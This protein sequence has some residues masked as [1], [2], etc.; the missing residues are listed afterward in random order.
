MKNLAV[1]ILDFLKPS[2]IKGFF[3]VEWILLILFIAL[4]G[5]LSSGTLLVFLLP[6]VF[7]YLLASLLTSL[8]QREQQLSGNSGLLLIA[9]SLAFTDQMLK[10][11]VNLTLPYQTSLPIL[12]DWLHIANE[13]NLRGSWLLETLDIS[14]VSTMGLVLFVLPF[15]LGALVGHSY[16][17]THYRKSVWA[18]AAYLGLFSGLLSALCDLLLRG[19]TLDYIQIPNIVTADMKDVLLTAG[20]AAF[21]AEAYDNPAV[22]LRWRGWHQES[23]AHRQLIADLLQFAWQEC[24]R[25]WR[26]VRR[27]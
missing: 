1:Q 19:Y 23:Q 25:M 13:R 16:Y 12:R 21:F 11:I 8:S 17:I 26:E 14:F 3:L 20:I 6:L 9:M 15:L 18:D 10:T 24:V 27:R 22:S 5:K 7:F 2:L 4:T